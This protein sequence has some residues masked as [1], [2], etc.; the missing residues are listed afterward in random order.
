M[1]GSDYILNRLLDLQGTDFEVV[2]CKIF[3]EKTIW[4]IKHREGIYECPSC[5][6]K[7]KACHAKRWI[8]LKDSPWAMR[9]C[10]WMVKRAQILCTCSNRLRVEH[11]PFRAKFH[12]LTQ[13]FVSFP[14]IT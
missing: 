9:E 11:M 3:E 12:H 2:D 4:Y 10:I 7:I 13:R 14:K 6:S 8:R 5:H 1:A